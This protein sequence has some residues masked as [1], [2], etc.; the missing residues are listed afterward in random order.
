MTDGRSE[1]AGPGDLEEAF[2]GGD[3]VVGHDE[4]RGGSLKWDVKEQE[5]TTIDRRLDKKRGR[6]RKK[7]H[8]ALELSRTKCVG[9]RN[10]VVLTGAQTIDGGIYTHCRRALA[11]H[12]KWIKHS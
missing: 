3:G 6:E 9:G 4:I 7:R 11:G 8:Q 2:G 5:V 12:E 10:Q 1:R